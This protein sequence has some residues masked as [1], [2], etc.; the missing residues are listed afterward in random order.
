MK[1][2]GDITKIDG[3]T[4]P[5]VDIITGG[6]PCQD[7]SIA[8]RR[9]GLDGERSG[10]FM[11]QIRIIKEMHD[12]SRRTNQPLRPRFMVWENVPGA[13]SSNGGEDFRV[14]LEETAR[15]I[16]PDTSIPRLPSGE[17]WSDAG[18]VLGDGWSIA[19]RVHSAEFWGV[20]QRRRRISLVADFRGTSAPEILFEREGLP[21]DSDT[22]GAEAQGVAD[23]TSRGINKAIS[24]QERGGKPGGGKGIL[25]QDNRTGALSTLNNQSVC[26]G[27]SPFESN[28]MKSDNPQSGIYEADT[29]RTLDLNGGSPSCNQGGMAIVQPES[30]LRGG[31]DEPIVA[32]KASFFLQS[33]SDG[34][35]DTLVATDYKDPQCVCYGLDRASFNQGKNA[36]FNFSVEEEL[37]QTITSRGCGGG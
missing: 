2:L 19:W 18:A 27:I 10:L 16:V 7:L 24:F 21:R 14:V 15:V 5:L 34:I 22:S 4:V 29:S 8:G 36:K 17:S 23:S 13:F 33:R 30:E 6:S 3:H 37:A 12:E 1:H 25:I 28:S 11:E 20:P 26:Y 31:R 35:A 9:A 32:S